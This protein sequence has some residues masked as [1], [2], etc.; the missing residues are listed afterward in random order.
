MK[1]TTYSFRSF[2]RGTRSAFTLVEL[3]VVIAIIGILVGLL[4]PAVQA[5][6]EAARRMQCSN[7]LKQLGL[8]AH[9]YE[10]SFR[11]FPGP[12]EDSLYGYSAQAKLLP[13]IEQTN[14]HNMIDYSQPLLIGVANSP[15]VNPPLLPVVGQSLGLF[16]CPSDPGSP[17]YTEANVQWAGTNYMV[18]AGPATGMSYCSRSDT[19]GMFWR[20]SNVRMG[21][22]PDGTSNTLLIA[23]TLFGNR[24][25]DTTTLIDYRTQISR[26]SGGGVCTATA[27]ELA[28][29]TPSRYEGRRA[30]QWARNITYHTF[31]NG[32]FGPNA[33]VPDVS[34]HGECISGSRSQHTG[35]IGG[36]YVDGSVH[37]LSDG[38]DIQAW[39][40]LF[41]RRDGQ[42]NTL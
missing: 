16:I 30:G 1:T 25:P 11:R 21:E 2:S 32:L 15:S 19:N 41:D 39:R 37:F 14:L 9:N 10:S 4:L 38:V 27:E 26:V 20:G 7:N 36:V 18:N 28:A 42:V 12:A 24:A 13:F 5:A 33:K 17:L 6:R 31:I 22:I 34:H 23:E 40:G 3:L 29:R 35:G 8:A